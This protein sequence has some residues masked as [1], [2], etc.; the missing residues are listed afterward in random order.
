[1]IETTGRESRERVPAFFFYAIG[2][3]LFIPV[4]LR[5]IYNTNDINDIIYMM[6]Y[7]SIDICYNDCYSMDRIHKEISKLI[8]MMHR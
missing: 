4:I 6:L 7:K 1:M 5:S 2:G 8:E 3:V